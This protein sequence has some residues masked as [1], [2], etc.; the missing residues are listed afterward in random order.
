[1]ENKNYEIFKYFHSIGALILILSV[2][3]DW[4][5]IIIYL[6][7]SSPIIVS[8]YNILTGWHTQY[9]NK[10]YESLF[11]VKDLNF[12]ISIAIIFIIVLLISV[13]I[14]ALITIEDSED[15]EKYNPIILLNLFACVISLF[16]IFIFPLIYLIPNKLYFPCI[17]LS[18]ETSSMTFYYFI[19]PGYIMLIFG[20]CLIFP[21][22]IFYYNT[23]KSFHQKRRT[24]EFFIENI[25]KNYQKKIDFDSLIAEEELNLKLNHIKEN[26]K[27][28]NSFK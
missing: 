21:R 28:R 9:N 4:Y 16:L 23:V 22:S 6:D 7:S 19:G 11:K 13:L 14:N 15:F 26:E 10:E 27:L 12:P 20:Y 18:Y 17:K 24:P 3:F 25:M 5:Y 8:R 1:M 2:F